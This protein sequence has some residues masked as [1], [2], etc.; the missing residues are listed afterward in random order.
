MKTEVAW[1]DIIP[2]KDPAV[3]NAV[4]CIAFSPDGSQVIAAVANRVFVYDTQSGEFIT[5]LR[6]HS[7]RVY[8]VAYSPDGK[9]FASGGADKRVILWA[10]DGKGLIRYVHNDSVQALAFSPVTN[11][12]V[13]CTEL[14]LGFC[15]P[16]KNQVNKTK[17]SSRA[18]CASWTHDGRLLA[19]GHFNGTI[20]FREAPLGREVCKIERTQ[21]VWC[22]SFCPVPQEN[23]QYLLAVGC[24]DQTLSF[25]N[26]QGKPV[27][28]ERKIGYDPCALSWQHDG[29]Y[30]IAGGSNKKVTMYNKDGTSLKVVSEQDQWIWTCAARPNSRDFAVGTEG[31]VISLIS[32][33]LQ[34]VHALAQNRYARRETLTDVI[35]QNLLTDQ[36]VYI[37]TRDVVKK[38]ALYRNFLAIQLSDRVLIYKSE[39]D[40]PTDMHYKMFDRALKP[41]ECSLLVITSQ[42][43]VLCHERQLQLYTF[44][45]DLLREWYLGSY[46]RYIRVLG[47]PSGKEALVVGLKNGAVLKVFIAEPAPLQ[48]VKH[49]ACVRCLDVSADRK[50]LALVDERSRLFVYDIQTQKVLYEAE[51][52]YSL[53]WNSE[54][55]AMLCYSGAGVLSIRCADFPPHRQAL[56]GHVVGFV[57]RKVFCLQQSNIV[58]RDVPLTQT[59][60]QYISAGDFANAYSVACLGV[61]VADWRALACKALL[62]LELRVASSAF[63]RVKD[64]RF[65]D[66]I[67]RIEATRRVQPPVEPGQTLQQARAKQNG[68]LVAEALAYLGRY[69]LAAQAYLALNEGR[70]AMQLFLDLRDW[71]QARAVVERLVQQSGSGGTSSETI[72]LLRE[73]AKWLVE[74]GDLTGAAEL[75]WTAQSY[76]TAFELWAQAGAW[77]TMA[78]RARSLPPR[79]DDAA[80]QKAA[81]LLEKAGEYA[82][83]LEIYTKLDDRKSSVNVL[84]QLRRWDEARSLVELYPE[85]RAGFFG[86]YA[87]WLALQGRFEEAYTA[88]RR[89]GKTDYARQLLLH[90]AYAAVVSKRYKDAGHFYWLLA[91]EKLKQLAALAPSNR[92]PVLLHQIASIKPT[93]QEDRVMG[94]FDSLGVDKDDGHGKS[95]EATTEHDYL[96][97]RNLSPQDKA[98][99]I[100]TLRK[101]YTMLLLKSRIYSAYQSI[102]ESLTTGV[103][104]ADSITLFQRAGFIAIVMRALDRAG[105]GDIASVLAGAGATGPLGYGAATCGGLS[106]DLSEMLTSA[107]TMLSMANDTAAFGVP[108]SVHTPAGVS[109]AHCLLTI[110][111]TGAEQGAYRVARQALTRLSTLVVPQ[112]FRSEVQFGSLFLR[113]KP[114]TDKETLSLTCY[115]CQSTGSMSNLTSDVCRVCL[116]PFIRSA[117]SQEPL[118]L[119]EFYLEPGISHEEAQRLIIQDPSSLCAQKEEKK[120]EKSLGSNI[121]SLVLDPSLKAM[122]ASTTSVASGGVDVSEYDTF[123]QQLMSPSDSSKLPPIVVGRNGLIA[124]PRRE[125]F[126]VD[127]GTSCME[128]RYF[129]ATFPDANIHQCFNCQE[130]F[131]LEEFEEFALRAKCCPVCRVEVSLDSF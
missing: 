85:T 102:H 44:K 31:G 103:T 129:R 75:E 28:K 86:A 89:A 22:L 125:V 116:H 10:P 65:V 81:L 24:W 88:F 34:V 69:A 90:L 8:C 60:E 124:M 53:S 52:V 130:L 120:A 74:S 119:V 39:T 4:S 17:I 95:S 99:M 113:G 97:L 71:T 21:P 100:N 43:L 121:Q 112:E 59:L 107:S 78:Q 29:K 58:T 128:P 18:L 41:L 68:L 127:L 27:G 108:R 50:K 94:T 117:V 84:V 67:D 25:Y 26:G 12:L 13:S 92:P 96:E 19:V 122:G 105:E 93:D 42:H 131:L 110:A 16:D 62:A 11:L 46:I 48:L 45:G 72:E 33:Q 82:L 56:S 64:F 55:A 87:E 83:A 70:R 5:A 14:E 66:L 104:S 126:V 47:G 98:A 15:V 40:E 91:A 118:P 63:A 61:P 109:Y 111:R 76:S 36:R 6:G 37:H 2:V 73:Q 51:N 115:R 35:V 77:A 79:I 32:A 9:K 101:E 54:H 20:S 106:E 7:D 57:G 123:M 3:K 23:D 80:L 38:V 30:F 49:D 114:F 1:T